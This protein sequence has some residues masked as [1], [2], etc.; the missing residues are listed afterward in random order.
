MAS[1]KEVE[2]LWDII[3]L[4]QSGK[5]EE[6]LEDLSKQERLVSEDEHAHLLFFGNNGSGKSTLIDTFLNKSTGFFTDD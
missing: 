2:T 3:E 1:S 4:N 6:D 5:V